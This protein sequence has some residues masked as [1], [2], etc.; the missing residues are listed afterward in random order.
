MR[1]I[2][3]LTIFFWLSNHTYAQCHFTNDSIYNFAELDKILNNRINLLLKNSDKINNIS[4][5]KI[6]KVFWFDYNGE[7]KKEDFKNQSFFNKIR[8][9]YYQSRVRRISLRPK[10]YFKK[11]L[12]TQIYIC[13]SIN[14]LIAVGD[15][16]QLFYYN[17]NVISDKKEYSEAFVKAI[18]D[19]NIQCVFRMCSALNYIRFGVNYNNE[20]IVFDWDGS[21]IKTYALDEFNTCCLDKF[22]YDNRFNAPW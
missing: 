6:I 12:K 20:I 11:Y 4:N 2:I 8:P 3:I 19:N 7:L 9:I 15:F 5:Y 1:I 21:N 18:I 16:T 14:R 22:I 13:D 10:S 17:L